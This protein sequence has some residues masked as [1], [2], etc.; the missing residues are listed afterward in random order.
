M[1]DHHNT[2]SL[3]HALSVQS[4]PLLALGLIGVDRLAVHTRHVDEW[5]GHNSG[6]ILVLRTLSRLRTQGKQARLAL[7]KD[8]NGTKSAENKQARMSAG[9]ALDREAHM[10]L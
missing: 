7:G 8:D 10:M 5:C 9:E 1:H 4:D 2:S 6:A 3:T